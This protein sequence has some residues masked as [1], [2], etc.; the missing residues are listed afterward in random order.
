MLN[1]AVVVGLALLLVSAWPDAAAARDARAPDAFYGFCRDHPA[2]CRRS[3]PSDPGDDFARRRWS[4]LVQVNAFV[5]RAIAETTDQAL[6]GRDDVWSLP[7]EAGDCEDY[8]L[9]KRHLLLR[10]GWPSGVLLLAS[11]RD[12]RGEGHAVLLVA[13]G[14]RFHVLDNRTNAIRRLEATPYVFYSRQSRADPRRWVG[15]A[16]SH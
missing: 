15:I 13:S 4:E 9:L 5:N 10:R 12:R 8:A 3:G 2:E 16:S 7:S 11:A 14:G 6:H 1:R